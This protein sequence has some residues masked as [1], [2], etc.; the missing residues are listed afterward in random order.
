MKVTALIA[1]TLAVQEIN[2]SHDAVVAVNTD[3]LRW[4]G[5]LAVITLTATANKIP[6]YLKK[7]RKKRYYIRNR[8]Q[9]S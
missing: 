4:M 9:I 5:E 8:R 7:E 3:M 1:T 2:A 6:T